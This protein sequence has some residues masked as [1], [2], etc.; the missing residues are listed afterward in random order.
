MEP[1]LI[2]YVRAERTEFIIKDY[3]CE[4]NIM[5][6]IESGSFIYNNGTVQKKPIPSK[7]LFLKAA[8]DISERLPLRHVFIF[9][10]TGAIKEFLQ[11][12]ISY[13]EIRT[14]YPQLSK[15][16]MSYTIIYILMTL[17]TKKHCL[18]I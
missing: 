13:S 1:E 4:D 18:Q 6:L 10:D 15:C 17:N 7:R 12:T 8:T 9:S 11:T 3:T 5:M 16:L 2:A 14:E